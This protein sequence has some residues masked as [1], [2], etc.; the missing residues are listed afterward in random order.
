[1]NI[2]SSIAS[3]VS[4]L[5]GCGAA[6]FVPVGIAAADESVLE[7]GSLIISS[8]NYEGWTGAVASLTVGTPLANTD[9]ATIPAVSNN[10]YVTVWNND[11]VDGSFGVTAPIYLTAVEPHSGRILHRL[12]VPTGLVVTSFPSKSELALH[13]SGITRATTWCSSAMP[14]QALAPSTSRTPMPWQVRTR[15]IP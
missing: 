4:L 8:S 12:R 11:T 10:N 15:P 13:L 9:T 2:H 7:P 1:M 14:A 6:V 3:A 5:V